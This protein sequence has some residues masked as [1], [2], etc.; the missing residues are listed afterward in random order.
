MRLTYGTFQLTHM[1]HDDHAVQLIKFERLA[2]HGAQ[3]KIKPYY[4][5]HNIAGFACKHQCTTVITTMWTESSWTFPER[6]TADDSWIVHSSDGGQ[7]EDKRAHNFTI[8]VSFC[9]V[10][11]R[12]NQYMMA[13]TMV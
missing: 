3:T 11:I 13:I 10:I 6:Y 4:S 1:S 5:A 9:T 8:K 2:S 12:L 7:Q